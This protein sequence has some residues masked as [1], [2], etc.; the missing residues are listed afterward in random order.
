MCGH[1]HISTGVAEAR[2]DAPETGVI[3]ACE[4]PDVDSGN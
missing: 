2:A 4:P 3:G 1:V